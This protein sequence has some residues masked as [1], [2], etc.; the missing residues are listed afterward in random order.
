MTEQ[1]KLT[2]REAIDELRKEAD[3]LENKAASI[4]E[5]ATNAYRAR[6][7]RKLAD[8]FERELEQSIE[9]TEEK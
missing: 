7:R 4:K 1:R 6:I 3:E 8:K 5:Y 9:Q 2:K